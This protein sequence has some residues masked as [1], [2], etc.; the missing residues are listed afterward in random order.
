MVISNYQNLTIISVRVVF[1]G[2]PHFHI[3]HNSLGGHAG[4]LIT[5]AVGV[6]SIHV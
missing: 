5:E 4:H 6:D 1:G 2:F 3:K